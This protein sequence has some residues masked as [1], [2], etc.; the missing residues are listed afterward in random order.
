MGVGEIDC[1]VG[2][3]GDVCYVVYDCGGFCEF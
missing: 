1:G 3:D 2:G